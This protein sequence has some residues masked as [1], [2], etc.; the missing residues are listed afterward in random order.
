MKTM[1]QPGA[2]KVGVVGTGLVGSSF[3]YALMLRGLAGEMVL[4]DVNPEKAV[5]EEMDFN[6]GLSFTR[7]M[8]ITAGTYADLAGSNVVVIAAGTNQKPGE[9]RLDLL[10]RNAAIFK[11]IVPQ[12]VRHNPNG[13][14][15]IATNP[16]DI[17]THISLK[18]VDLPPSRIIGSGTILDTSRFRFLL[19]Q[20]YHVDTRSVH[21]YIVGEHGDSEIPLWSLANIGGVRLQEFAPLQNKPYNQDD[22]NRLFISVRDAAYEIIKRKGATSYAIG[23]GL[24]S[25]V[26]A[27]LGNYRSVLSVSTVMMGQYGVKDICLSLPCVVGENGIEEVLTLNISPE[28][29]EGFR[30]S[31]EKLKVTLQ[32]LG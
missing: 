22:M 9:T 8:K 28:E 7:P 16:V 12:V 4:V 20:Y 11:E 18:G 15:L 19:G 25:I 27:I 2:R 24:L 14:I 23:L 10:A 30:R 17:L 31:A 21:A 13:I 3:A 32:A 26:E 6:H 1:S 29:E 5:G